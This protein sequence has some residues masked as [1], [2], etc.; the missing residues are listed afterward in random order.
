MGSFIWKYCSIGP[1]TKTIKIMF[2]NHSFIL[3]SPTTSRNIAFLF[4][5]NTSDNINNLFKVGFDVHGIDDV[6]TFRGCLWLN[7]CIV[8][9]CYPFLII[10][11]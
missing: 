9:C 5:L 7:M 10:Y 1:I 2:I 4:F 11:V 6:Y 3:E 8:N